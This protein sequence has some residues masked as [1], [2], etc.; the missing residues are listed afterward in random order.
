[1]PD[2]N[3]SLGILDRVRAGR[4][5]SLHAGARRL[6]FGA[7]FA[8]RTSERPAVGAAP[9][10]RPLLS[11]LPGVHHAEA[12]RARGSTKWRLG[13]GRGAR[14]LAQAHG[15][16]RVPAFPPTRA[17]TQRAG[18]KARS[19]AALTERLAARS[20][21]D[22]TTGAG[23]G[24]AGTA[25]WSAAWGVVRRACPAPR[26]PSTAVTAS[27]AGQGRAGRTGAQAP[28]WRRPRDGL[29][30]PFCL[31]RRNGGAGC[32]YPGAEGRAPGPLAASSGRAPQRGGK[33]IY[34]LRKFCHVILS[35]AILRLEVRH[36]KLP[37]R[38]RSQK[39]L[40]LLFA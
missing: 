18:A 2:T 12:A 4:P 6:P 37:G 25:R 36:Y 26:R 7:I 8:P 27:Q 16:A 14:P 32:P 5:T 33:V 20:G 19:A 11:G 30:P 38:S 29:A 15:A 17:G 23:A 21:L 24:L 1:M 22:R 10:L 35:G 40:V 28:R 3:T 34:L 39:E 13:R 9:A 31:A